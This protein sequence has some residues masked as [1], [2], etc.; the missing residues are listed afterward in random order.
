MKWQPPTKTCESSYSVL[1]SFA[2][3]GG[4]T[5]TFTG[6]NLDVAQNPQLVFSS[7]ASVSSHLSISW[8]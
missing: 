6:E 8:L 5:L 4:I 7:G 2:F 3:R 1:V